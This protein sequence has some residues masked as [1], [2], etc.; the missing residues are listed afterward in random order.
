MHL[1]LPDDSP[2][3]QPVHPR[4]RAFGPR[5]LHHAEGR[6]R[7]DMND[8]TV[9]IE[10]LSPLKRALLALEHMQTRLAEVE[11]QDHTPIAIIGM[12][13]RFP[14]GA[15]TPELFWELLAESRDAIAEVPPE[16]WS[17]DQ[18][19]DPDPDVPGKMYTREGG[20]ITGADQFDP[21]FFGI[22]PR[23]AQTMDPQQRVL[24]EVT[25]EALEYANLVPETLT[26][27]R[28]GVFM[29]VMNNDYT[30]LQMLA[31]PINI[32][33]YATTGNGNSVIAGRL[34]YVFGLRGPSVAVDTV[35][36]SSLV[37]LHLA[38]QSL[39]RGE[40]DLAL[41]GGV[42]LILSPQG[43]I[44]LSKAR[45]IAPDGRCKTFD[46]RADGYGRGEGCG[47]VVLKRLKDALAAG[48]TIQAVVRGTAVN[49]DGRSSGLTAPNGPAQQ[50]LL[51]EALHNAQL[52]PHE[53]GYIEAHG[54][55]TPLGDPIEVG[56][57][58]EVFGKGRIAPLYLGSVKT[59]IGHLEAAAGMAGLLKVILALK[60]EAIPAHLHLTQ[61]NPH[62]DLERIPAQIPTKLTPWTEH[63]VG[64]VSSFGLTGTNAHTLLE[65]APQYRRS[66]HPSRTH[67]LLPL[68]ARSPEAL[69]KLAIAHSEVLQNQASLQNHSYTASL[70]RSHHPYRLAV[71][72]SSPIECAQYLAE[73]PTTPH[74]ISNSS[75]PVFV[76]CGQGAQT[77]TMGRQLLN[78]EPIFRQAIEECDRI[79]QP[80]ANWSLLSELTASEKASRLHETAIAQPILF[81]L[82]I[83]LT[84]L[85]ESWGISPVA[86]VGHS[87]GEVAATHVAGALSLADALCVVYHRSRLMA[88]ATGQGQMAAVECPLAEVKQYLASYADK[89][90]IAAINSPT[91]VTISGEAQ[92]LQT[93]LTEL[94][95][96]GIFTKLLQVNAAFHSQQMAPYQTPLQDVLQKLRPIPTHLPIFSTVTGQALSGEAFDGSYWAK[97]IRMPVQFDQA[98]A[99][100]IG[101]GYRVFIEI[102]PHP[103]LSG[104]IRQGLQDQP[105]TI[106]ASLRRDKPEQ[107]T[108]LEALAQLYMLGC[109]V[110]WAAL[111]P[112]GGTAI[113]LPP[114]PWNH[115]RYWLPTP[116]STEASAPPRHFL[117]RALCSSLQLQTYFWELDLGKASF[118]YLSDHRIRG[119]MV[120]PVALFID[121][122][123]TA[124]LQVL[125]TGIPVINRL[126]FPLVGYLPEVESQTVQMVFS[127]LVADRFSFQLA[128]ADEGTWNILAKGEVNMA[129]TMTVPEA[130]TISQNYP[131]QFSGSSYYQV[132]RSWGL[133]YGSAF[134]GIETLWRRDGAALARLTFTAIVQA[135]FI[136]ALHPALLD[137]C[138]QVLAAALPQTAHSGG[139]SLRLPLGLHQLIC[140]RLPQ[141]G[142]VLW[143]QATVEAMDG[144]FAGE[145]QLLDDVG[146]VL[147]TVQGFRP[148]PIA[149]LSVDV[150]LTRSELLQQPPDERSTALETYL[151][152]L[153]AAVLRLPLKKFTLDQPLLTLGM[154]SLVAVELRSRLE[155]DLGLAVPMALFLQDPTVRELTQKL[156]PQLLTQPDSSNDWEDGEL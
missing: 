44:A 22:S 145:V 133:E 131:E 43:S 70:H 128:Q 17:L 71:V 72:G 67:Y 150:R 90:T 76:F 31:D 61:L 32:D 93:F 63:Q 62:L 5:V 40:S 102:G 129:P 69:T 3:F 21:Q 45:A 141:K 119:R 60:H 37:A 15:N 82:Q 155:A 130:I 24:L 135:D 78:E 152:Q 20:F 75:G 30:Q 53:V 144:D 118:P 154:D 73:K 7:F 111:Y 122:V 95:T 59:N 147:L 106:L 91:A 89:L 107:K 121:M 26:G 140:Y 13:C 117:G 109:R 58:T 12:G 49:H 114:Y 4:I 18:Y 136:H 9:R 104:A 50:A 14:G 64:G 1:R 92:A 80:L 113:T 23:E 77:W 153:V 120:L 143:A 105:G 56:A 137:T 146:N 16:L 11:G 25:W 8:N 52:Q 126:E 123:R 34:S 110:N 97:N 74:A 142:E 100:L 38:C 156:L 101:Q 33:P 65:K 81:A 86:V 48:D 41:A 125:G 94:Q 55:G 2:S 96:Q 84:R 115:E 79:L 132:L 68:S 57:L 112:Q 42:N 39:R 28:T 127:P 83:A 108:M 27:S 10:Q 149:A 138:F 99:E 47:V 116:I 6:G 103:V 36:S 87:V 19:Y 51:R 85:W 124:A 35:C 29:G 139:G 66:T 98:M 88:A 134:Q 46:A 54:T 148:Q 151:Y